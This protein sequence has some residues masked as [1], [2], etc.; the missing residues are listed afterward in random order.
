MRQDLIDQTNIATSRLQEE[1]SQVQDHLRRTS[2][3]KE[4]M[5]DR[6]KQNI[7]SLQVK[8]EEITSDKLALVEEKR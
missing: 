1:L 8:L 3:S 2:E 6:Y 4:M 5:E 7:K